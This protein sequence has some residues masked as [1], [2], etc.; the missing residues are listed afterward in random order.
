MAYESSND[1]VSSVTDPVTG[2]IFYTYGLSGERLTMT[3]PGGGVFTYG[4]GGTFQALSK[5]DPNSLSKNLSRITDDQGRAVDYWLDESGRPYLTRFNQTFDTNLAQ[6]SYQQ[7][8]N[9]YTS[10]PSVWLSQLTN[11][12]NWRVNAMSSWQA[13]VQSQNQY[14][15]DASGQRLTNAILSPDA[16]TRTETYVYDELSRLTSVNYGDGV[17]QSYSFDAMGNRLQKQD[18]ATGTENCIYNAANM[19]LCHSGKSA[20]RSGSDAN[21]SSTCEIMLHAKPRRWRKAASRCLSF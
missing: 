13:T 15:H 2:A 11:T 12:W 1:R 3:L 10:T 5:D 18:S 6:L 17:T 9:T 21:V 16:S 14:T 19:L 4:Y 20:Y 8:A 7:A